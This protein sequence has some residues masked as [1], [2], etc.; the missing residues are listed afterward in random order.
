MP[1]ESP[2][3]HRSGETPEQ[4]I[5]RN[6]GGGPA[7]YGQEPYDPAF[8]PPHDRLQGVNPRAIS[9]VVT[10][11]IP[12]TTVN[13]DWGIK[14]V[15]SSMQSMMIGLFDT[16][17]QLVES[18]VGDSRN[19]ASMVNRHGALLSTPIRF[20]TPKGLENDRTA[21]KVLSAWEKAW[22]FIGGEAIL[23]ELLQWSTYLGFGIAQLLWDTTRPVW[24]PYLQ[25]FH[26]RYAWYHWTYRCFVAISLDGQQPIFGGNGHWVLHAPHGEHRGWVR[27][28][29]RAVAPW[30]L[31]RN[32][33]LRDWAR[34]SER[35]GMPWVVGKTPAAANKDDINNFGNALALLGQ[36]SVLTIP[37]GVQENLSYAIDLLEAKTA[38]ASNAFRSLIEICNT[39]I[40]LSLNGT[41]LTTEVSGG[42]LAASKTHKQNDNQIVQS[43]GRA[44]A[45]TLETQIMRPFTAFNFGDPRYTPRAAWDTSPPED[46][47]AKGRSF[48]SFAK[49]LSDIS[50]AGYEVENPEQVGKSMGL[51][52]KL[53]KKDPQLVDATGTPMQ[54]Q[55][56]G[57]SSK[58]A[59]PAPSSFGK[60]TKPVKRPETPTAALSYFEPGSR[61]LA[62][63]PEA[64][65]ITFTIGVKR[66]VVIDDGIGIVSISGP[67][68]HHEAPDFDSYD[69]I[70]ERLQEAV[71]SDDVRAVVLKFDSPGG[72]A[73]GANEAHK[74]ILELRA[75]SGKPIFAYADE[76]M[77]SAA[78]QL[79]CA[80][81]EIWLPETATIGHVG[82]ISKMRSVAE[83]NRKAGVRVEFVVSGAYKADGQA[84]APIDDGVLARAKQHV[85]VFARAYF[86][87]VDSSRGIDSEA[88]QA[89]IFMGKKAVAIGLADG[90]M[91]WEE[92]L[93]T[94]RESSFGN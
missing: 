18:I 35:N 74:K 32:Y 91:G 40:T 9:R 61:A 60:P 20:S 82:V 52:I 17:A 78:Y 73:A 72:L 43:E 14:G 23:S 42:S 19:Q 85:N 67:L 13:T 71:A 57:Q 77:C 10:R 88:L 59:K 4:I 12:M 63:R 70:L 58:K 37:Q 1:T 84:D 89:G 5:A 31:A 45:L 39:E 22:P 51:L 62:I 33:A 11:E 24:R 66:P 38:D 65:D 16:S 8:A 64:L 28:A 83:Q 44:L 80:C 2:Y 81:Q 54:P 68:M 29:M 76:E 75:T 50:A 6:V 34:Y 53:K 47:E 93:R 48:E 69:S 26:P 7:V 41:N 21:L 3:A 86:R 27:G 49:G 94:V 36:E 25:V 30:W 15:R 55:V 90:V 56:E 79:G 46:E 92:F 87:S